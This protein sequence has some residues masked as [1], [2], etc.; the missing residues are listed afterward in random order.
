M[1]G[2]DVELR[3]EREVVVCI[4]RFMWFVQVLDV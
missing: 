1:I 3:D 2:V 4:G